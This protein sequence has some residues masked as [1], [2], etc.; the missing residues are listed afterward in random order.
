MIL[1]DDVLVMRR[2]AQTG[3]SDGSEVSVSARIVSLRKERGLTLQDCAR[4]SGVAA[5]TLSK[6]ERGELSPTVTTLQKIATGFNLD[7]AD[8][9][10]AS[11]PA[12]GG[13]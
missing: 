13:P 6:I 1:N 8:L 9:L 12:V 2:A 11:A 3:G 5:S 10:S 7:A 4:L